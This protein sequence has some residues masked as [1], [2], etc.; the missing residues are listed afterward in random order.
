MLDQ[1]DTIKFLEEN[2]HRTHFD[3]NC[4]NVFFDP[5]PRVM[6]IKTKISKGGLNKLKN[7]CTAKETINKTNK[8]QNMKKNSANEATN[9]GSISK[10]CKHLIQLYLL[11]YLV[12]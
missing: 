11:I 8:P 4:S 5:P 6:K 7:F 2:T 9:K 10:I 12:F 1:I 3:I